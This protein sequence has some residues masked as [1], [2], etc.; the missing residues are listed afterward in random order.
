MSSHRYLPGAKALSI[1][2]RLFSS[3]GGIAPYAATISDLY[4]DLVGE[5][6]F[7]GKGIY[8]IDAFEASLA[9]RVPDN[10]LLSHDLFEGV[11]ARAGLASDIEVIE[12]FPARYDVAAKRQHRW[13]RG[14]WQLLPWLKTSALPLTGR[15]KM[16]GNLRR[17]LLP[18]LMLAG[19]AVSWQLPLSMAI[20]STLLLLVVMGAPVLLSLATSFIP[21]RAKAKLRHHYHLWFDELT[22]GSSQV[23]LQVVF[24]PDQA[25]RMLDAIARTLNRVLI[26]HRHLLE[27]TSAAQSMKSPALSIL[28]FYQRMAPGTALGLAVAISALWS[29]GDVWPIA[30]PMALLW[31]AA[32]AVAW[33]LSSN[34]SAVVQPSISAD[35]ALELRVIAR[36]TWRYFETFVTATD[37]RLPPDNFQEDPQPVLAQR[38]SPTNMGLYFL[39]TLAARDFGWIGTHQALER[40]EATL[41]VML[42]LPRYRGHFYNWYATH[43]LRPLNPR[44]VSTVDSGNLAGHLIVIANACETW[45]QATYLPTR[46][47]RRYRRHF[48]SC[49]S[50][51]CTGLNASRKRRGSAHRA[52]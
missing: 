4:Q 30:V 43:D 9:G 40:L 37:N 28:G 3:P 47:T 45:Q 20:I 22:L 21:F 19:F 33:W 8:A 38:T 27:W 13:T 51:T 23:L 24:L 18:P 32:P 25:W 14:D 49:S 16:L 46:P 29:A 10:S 2:Q 1:Y 50:G 6:S 5:G 36:R 35:E 12:D 17:P 52:L 15:M 41:N 34:K 39:S 31:L 7:A 44:Y 26:T 48:I 42:T 11:F